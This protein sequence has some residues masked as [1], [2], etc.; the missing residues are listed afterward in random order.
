MEYI[1]NK[2]PT[3]HQPHHAVPEERVVTIQIK[4]DLSAKSG[5]SWSPEVA[6][7]YM[8]LFPHIIENG[9]EIQQDVESFNIEDLL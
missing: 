4:K 6:E 9:F 8:E 5:L 1:L 2:K 3:R 7:F